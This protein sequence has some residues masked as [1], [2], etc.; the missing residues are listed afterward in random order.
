MSSD[1][2]INENRKIVILWET[3]KYPMKENR[4][5]IL[6]DKN[7]KLLIPMGTHPAWL[8]SDVTKIR[9]KFVN[10]KVDTTIDIQKIEFMQ[11]NRE[12]KED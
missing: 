1:Y 12:R 9:L 3:D 7:G 5:I 2:Q 10:M 11:L 8:Y 4:I 6:E